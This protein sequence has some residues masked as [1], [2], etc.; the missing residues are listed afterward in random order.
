MAISPAFIQS[1]ASP[2]RSLAGDNGGPHPAGKSDGPGRYRF[3][4]SNNTDPA[5]FC[6]WRKRTWQ[7]TTVAPAGA[8][9]LVTVPIKVLFEAANWLVTCSFNQVLAADELVTRALR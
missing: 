9:R 3:K 5:A 7:R 4:S 1:S 6:G 2:Q 8:T